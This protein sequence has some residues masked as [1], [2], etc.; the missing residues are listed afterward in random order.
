MNAKLYLQMK[1]TINEK[2]KATAVLCNS[3][4]S[5]FVSLE[6]DQIRSWRTKEGHLCVNHRRCYCKSYDKACAFE[7]YSF[8]C[9][10]NCTISIQIIFV[11]IQIEAVFSEFLSYP[12]TSGAFLVL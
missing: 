11:L 12:A 7:F 5:V 2:K 9:R 8:G 6:F 1:V 4:L 3:V 10:S